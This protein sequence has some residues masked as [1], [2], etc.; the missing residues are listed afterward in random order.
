[1]RNK[2]NEKRRKLENLW[3]KLNKK[4]EKHYNGENDKRVF[5]EVNHKQ[6][7]KFQPT[8]EKPNKV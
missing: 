7:K 4:T 6:R 8:K 1:M 2:L 5:P 3:K